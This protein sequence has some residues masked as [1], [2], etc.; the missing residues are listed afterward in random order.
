[1]STSDAEL[2]VAVTR[3]PLTESVHRG[4][5]AVSDSQGR[6]LAFAG[7]PHF[8][9]FARSTAKLLQAIPLL[10]AEGAERLSLT[11]AETAIMCASHNG[12]P[13]HTRAA[14]SILAKAGLDVSALDCGPQEPMLKR[15]ADR[16]K[17]ERVTA[18]P[19]HNNC[20]GKHA[21]MLALA[22][23]M[24]VSTHQYTRPDHPVQQ[25]MLRTISE[26][27]GIPEERTELGV[28]GCGVPV[29]ALPLAALAY[30]YARLG[31]PDGLP[32]KRAEACRRIVK[33]I[34]RSPFHVAG[35][36]RYDTSLVEI[37]GGR[38]IGKMGAEGLYAA[39]VPEK[40]IGIAIK[41]EDGA[42]RA[43]YPAATEA[44]LQL[45]LL[46]GEEAKRL[47]PFHHPAVINRRDETV[48][49]LQPSFRLIRN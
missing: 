45:G 1:M 47:S 5:I 48:G 9:T 8:Y 22:S 33:A 18:S 29:F 14:M 2:L 19:I 36:E 15:E 46:S 40:G 11:D 43:L 6:L 31:R 42:E 24:Q 28:D 26:M 27:C 12:E 39:T 3:G 37:T 20:S 44:L 21:G 30:G 7:N 32:P 17:Y 10:E 35:T 4:H 23:L 49:H 38:I 41:V 13:E 25:K 34:R 16:L